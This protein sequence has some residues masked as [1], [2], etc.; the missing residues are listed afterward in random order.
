MYDE[1][2]E[3]PREIQI[4]SATPPSTDSPD[5]SFGALD[6]FADDAFDEPAAPPKPWYRRTGVLATIVAVLLVGL[7]A[8]TLAFIRNQP[9]TIT[10][11]Y[12]TVR[13]G[14]LAITV[15]ATGPLQAAAYGASFGVSGR[16]AEI[17][18][19]VGQQVQAGQQLAKLDATALQDALN[20]AQANADQAYQQEQTAIFNC[21]NPQHGVTPTPNCVQAAEAAYNV[22]LTQLQTAKDN[23]ANATLYAPHAGVVSAVNGSVGNS[24]GS[25][26]T[27]GSNSVSGFVLIQD[28]SVFQIVAS[29]N[30]AD[31]A[32]LA[33]GQTATFTVSA[34]S[35]RQFRGTISLISPFGQTSS[36][37][38]TYPV[39]IDVDMTSVQ[40]AKL[41]PAMTATVTIIRAQR[42]GVLL[43]PASVLTFARQSVGIT[44][45]S[46]SLVQTSQLRDALTQGRQM[47]TAY[48]Q[49][50]KDYVN[51]NPTAAFVLETTGAAPHLQWSVKPIVIGL[52]DGANY[53][54]LSGLSQGEQVVTGQSGGATA[55]PAAGGNGRNP[56]GGGG[57]GGGGTGGGGKG[58]G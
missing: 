10:Y 55:T 31:I 53:E 8:G 17:D 38:V 41:F 27:G 14:N 34:Y 44:R 5:F 22:A 40:T 13:S 43:I 50:N 9:Q 4:A 23:L 39:T 37:V 29:V 26:S 36:N 16:L 58:G 57:T 12:G 25:S 32:N 3:G 42:S 11:T 56:F 28:T 49:Q 51:D 30:E 35:T 33:V 1:P 18:V 15:S 52:T 54:V 24:P 19:K 2:Q 20:Q 21:N 47:L 48:E 45:S 6:L 7:I 46:S